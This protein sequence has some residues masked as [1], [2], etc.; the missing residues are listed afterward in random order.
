MAPITTVI[1]KQA[2]QSALSQVDT[3]LMMLHHVDDTQIGTFKDALI[4]KFGSKTIGILEPANALT[5]PVSEP[6]PT[7]PY[8]P[9]PDK[10][11]TVVDV[12]VT[13]IEL[14]EPE[15]LQGDN[16]EQALQEGDTEQALNKMPLPSLR[17]L[18]KL[19]GTDAPGTKANLAARL[20]AIV[21]QSDVRVA[22][23]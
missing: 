4:V 15:P 2:I 11:D 3:A 5:N 6:E 20:K 14:T 10:T 12:Q 8:A 1:C 7:A 18:A 16:I 23:T 19:K 13:H 22:T 21:I 17:S 9:R